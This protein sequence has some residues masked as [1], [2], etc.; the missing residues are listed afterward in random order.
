MIAW[1]WGGREERVKVNYGNQV[2]VNNSAGVILQSRQQEVG[3]V[4][5]AP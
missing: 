1:K 5:S 3:V 2:E 4:T